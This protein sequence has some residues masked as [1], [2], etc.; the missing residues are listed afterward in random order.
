MFCNEV[1]SLVRIAFKVKEELGRTPEPQV[2]PPPCSYGGLVPEPP[3]E[4]LMRLLGLAAGQKWQKVHAIESGRTG[5]SGR[6]QSC[7]GD[8]E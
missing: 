3:I 5:H 4:C 1:V 7:G 6:R 2:L 8:I